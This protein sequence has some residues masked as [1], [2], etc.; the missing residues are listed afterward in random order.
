MSDNVLLGM[1]SGVQSSTRIFQIQTEYYG[2][3][4]KK[5]QTI[6]IL[7]GKIVLNK[8]T[9]IPDDSGEEFIRRIVVDQHNEVE[10]DLKRRLKKREQRKTLPGDTQK[11]YIGK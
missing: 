2:Q 5:V 3:S 7:D 6:V 11:I 4:S 9:S 1:L 10:L 8:T